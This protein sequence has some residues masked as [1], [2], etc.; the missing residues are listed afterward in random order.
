M[1]L[2]FGSLNL[3]YV[4][5]VSR[6]PGPGE[7]VSGMGFAMHPG[8]KGA[9]QAYAAARLGAAVRLVGRVGRDQPGDTLLAHLSEG[10]V[11]VS[12]VDRLDGVTTGVAVI[13]VE[14]AGQNRIVVVPGANGTWT[15]PDVESMARSFTGARVVLVQL[16]T[17]IDAVTAAVRQARRAGGLVILEP[18]T[19]PAAGAG[20]ARRSGLPDAERG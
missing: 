15:G 4:A 17:P 20:S 18:L 8:G 14:A 5:F 13:V 19:G 3:D 7:T 6:A 10:R 1:I 16:E 9:N 12:G 11:D 2:V